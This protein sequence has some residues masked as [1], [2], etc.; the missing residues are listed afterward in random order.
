MSRLHIAGADVV[1]VTIGGLAGW[2][3]ALGLLEAW[4]R[5]CAR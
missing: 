3:L 2:L 1:A 4:L 5:R